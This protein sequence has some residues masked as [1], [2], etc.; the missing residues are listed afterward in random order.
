MYCRMLSRGWRVGRTSGRWSST[1]VSAMSSTKNVGYTLGGVE[2]ASVEEEKDVGVM[3]YQT[4]KLSLQC[5]R[6]SARVNQVLGQLARGVG[7]RDKDTFLRL[8]MVYVR[9]HLEYALV[10]W[11]RRGLRLSDYLEKI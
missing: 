5:A 8:Y 10:V 4:M 3:I 7:Y 11:S 6:D 1:P 9:P 2:L